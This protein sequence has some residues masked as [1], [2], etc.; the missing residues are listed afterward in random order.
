MMPTDQDLAPV[1]TPL[2][3][4]KRGRTRLRAAL[5]EYERMK[6]S[7]ERV[8]P[9]HNVAVAIMED[10]QERGTTSGWTWCTGKVDGGLDHSWVE[11]SV[12]LARRRAA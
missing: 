12:C 8:G 3:T 6:D 11:Y 7:P 9:C 10:L 5:D 2:T 1:R 4:L